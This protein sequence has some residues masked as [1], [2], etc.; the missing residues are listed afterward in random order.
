MDIFERVKAEKK[1]LSR[2]RQETDEELGIRFANSVKL[3]IERNVSF[4]IEARLSVEHIRREWLRR[5]LFLEKSINRDRP[6]I[7]VLK[8]VGYSTGNSGRQE[9]V[10]RALVDYLMCGRIIPAISSIEYDQEW[11]NRESVKRFYKLD[12]ILK[13]FSEYSKNDI[14]LMRANVQWGLDRD[15]LWNRWKHLAGVHHGENE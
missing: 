9:H 6:N 11:G 2:I 15:Y 7:G 4:E 13:N 12:R 3:I 1:F 14:K 8:G 10:R 5:R